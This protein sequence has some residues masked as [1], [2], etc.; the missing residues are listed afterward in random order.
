MT[1][2][3]TTQP[4]PIQ[5]K[6]TQFW[7]HQVPAAK[8]NLIWM[9]EYEKGRVAVVDGPSAT[10]ALTYCK[11]NDLE[12]T[13]ILNTHTHW[14]HIGINMDLHKKG[15]MSGIQ[16]YGPKKRASE[17]PFLTMPLVDGDSVSLGSLHGRVWLTEGHIDGHIS[18]I[19]DEFLFCGD[20]LFAG[21]C[22]YLF[23]GPP[24]KMHHSLQKL[25]SLAPETFVCCAHEYTEDNLLFALSVDP[26]NTK[27]QE[28]SLSVKE[29]RSDGESTLPSTIGLELETNPFIRV[30]SAEE[31]A[32]RR[33]LKNTGAYRE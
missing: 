25:A 1:H 2:I 9:I 14:D 32:S 8:D 28:R 10:E 7:V 20:T 26:E 18:Y 6:S 27:L 29:T 12:I 23:D 3:I 11:K 15:M 17:V 30:S 33:E 22:G 16:V 31:F 4:K 19:F 5:S 21:G 13:T 24:I